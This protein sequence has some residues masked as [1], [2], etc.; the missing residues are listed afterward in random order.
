MVPLNNRR[1]ADDFEHGTGVDAAIDMLS[2]DN[3]TSSK[4]GYLTQKKLDGMFRAYREKM[5]PQVKEEYPGL[6]LTQY[7]E[8]IGKM[9]KK[10]PENPLNS[11]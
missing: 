2:I 6:R 1:E 11:Q 4:S 10:A 3:G 9:W 7:D 8:K 5:L